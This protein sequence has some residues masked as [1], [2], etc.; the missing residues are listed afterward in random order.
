[1]IATKIK[2]PNKTPE[3]TWTDQAREDRQQTV[4]KTQLQEH[5]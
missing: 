3:T 4:G 1:M 2:M 5:F